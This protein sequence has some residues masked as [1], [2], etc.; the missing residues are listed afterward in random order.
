MCI[1]DR[2]LPGV[3]NPITWQVS[4]GGTI[5]D[6]GS[7]LIF[8][9][10]DSA[11]SATVT[12]TFC[13]SSTSVT[14]DVIPPTGLH[15]FNYLGQGM[16]MNMPPTHQWIMLQYLAYIYVE[17]DTVNF[18]RIELFEG[19]SLPEPFGYFLTTIVPTPP[20]HVANGPHAMTGEVVVGKGTR[21]FAKDNIYYTASTLPYSDGVVTWANQWRYRVINI[22][23]GPYNVETTDQQVTLEKKDDA[24]KWIQ[25]KDSS[26][27]YITNSDIP[28]QPHWLGD[29][30]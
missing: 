11:S 4:G 2:S 30:Q 9:A 21:L 1:R 15:F 24:L 8:T 25:T 16:E 28:L 18:S 27:G 29:S 12:A 26:G 6:T 5:D 3:S 23:N 19:D 10:S 17:P 7:P 22:A 20:P 14:F 13:Q